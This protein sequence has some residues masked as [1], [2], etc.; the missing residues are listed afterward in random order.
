MKHFGKMV[1]HE[2]AAEW[3]ASRERELE[4]RRQWAEARQRQERERGD[5]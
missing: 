4:Q 1:E 5:G 3:L 2:E